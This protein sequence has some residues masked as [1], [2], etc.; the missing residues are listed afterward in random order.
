[1]S[2][3]KLTRYG[4]LTTQQILAVD[5]LVLK[6]GSEMTY[7]EIGELVGVAVKTLE[8]WRKIPEFQ[9]E[10]RTR[11]IELMGESLPNVLATLTRKAIGGN[12]KS[13][14]LYLKA[15]G[16][17]KQEIDLTAQPGLM[18]DNRSNEAIEFEIEEL[19]R[20]LQLDVKIEEEIT[21]V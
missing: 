15:L 6:Q 9:K 17:L 2:G 20:E 10:V 13:I 18:L 12:N 3:S 19:R 11:T 21:D 4:D 14:E 16:L 1:M 8:R 7:T 5:L